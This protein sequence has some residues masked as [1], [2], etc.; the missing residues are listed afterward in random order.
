MSKEKII[1]LIGIVVAIVA[2]FVDIPYFALILLVLGL[3]MGFWFAREDHVRL[4]VSA[5]GLTAFAHLFGSV[6]TIGEYL[7]AIIGNF[8]LLAAG[9][10]TFVILRNI[11]GR[12][13]PSL[14]STG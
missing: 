4:I 10:A 8:G 12:Y 9:A 14:K 1:G 13:M 5:L 11:Y 7:E 3:I 6:P 2:A